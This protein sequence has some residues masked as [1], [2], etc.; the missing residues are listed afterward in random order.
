[1]PCHFAMAGHLQALPH[2]VC[3]AWYSFLG[4]FMDVRMFNPHAPSNNNTS[5]NSCYRKHENEKKRAYEQRIREVE[6]ASFTPSAS[7]GMAKQSTTFYK[8]LASLLAE[9]WDQHY[10]TALY[11]LHC[12]ISFSLLRS[13]IQCI[14]GARSS[15]AQA[16]KS[17]T[18][19]ATRH[20]S[21]EITQWREETTLTWICS[22]TMYIHVD[23]V[24]IVVC[25]LYPVQR[26]D[27]FCFVKKS[28]HV[29]TL[30]TVKLVIKLLTSVSSF[31]SCRN[32][33]IMC[34]Y[35]VVL[36]NNIINIYF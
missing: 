9:K 32:Y 21:T 6:H 8:R 25:N 33:I 15:H 7:G 19:F 31:L 10:S 22:P 1:M 35:K 16:I 34:K 17:L 3:E 18:W 26:H 12:Q 5:I 20:S 14:R 27:W 4:V 29:T 30:I 28:M 2:I 36:T 11:W 23:L 13:A 24:V